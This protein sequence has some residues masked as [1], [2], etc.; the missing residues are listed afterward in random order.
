MYRHVLSTRQDFVDE[1]TELSFIKKCK[2]E[3]K[4]G[5]VILY[6]KLS[7][8]DYIFRMSEILDDIHGVLRP[9]VNIMITY[10]VKPKIFL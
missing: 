10:E 2:V 4:G 3:E 7:L 9:K 8:F 1:L 6:I 5:I